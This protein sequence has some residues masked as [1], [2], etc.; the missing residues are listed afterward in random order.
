MQQFLALT[1][2]GIEILLAEELKN[3]NAQQVVQ[4]PEGVYFTATLADAYK[5]CLYCRLST[6]ILLNENVPHKRAH[7]LSHIFQYGFQSSVPL[8]EKSM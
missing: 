1:S 5:I 4:K 7:S 3:L 6:R 8:I 2:F